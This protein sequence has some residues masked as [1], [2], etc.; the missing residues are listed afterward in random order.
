MTSLIISIL[1]I[2]VFAAGF[3][4]YYTMRRPAKEDFSSDGLKLDSQYQ[5]L[6]PLIAIVFAALTYY[7]WPTLDKQMD[8]EKVKL[9]SETLKLSGDPR[10]VN[11]SMQDFILSLRTQAFENPKR[12]DLWFELGGA[13]LRLNMEDAALASWQ[14]AIQIEENPDWMVAKAQIL[15]AKSEAE[16]RQKAIKLLQR[17]LAKAPS[18]QGALLTLGFTY[19]RGQQY[20]G[21]IAVWER[22]RDLPGL[23]QRSKQFIQQQIN[24]AKAL[25]ANRAQ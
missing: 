7:L 15:G 6:L 4:F 14:R 10:Q 2:S 18:H 12:G 23:S 11:M 21:A 25:V 16:S 19:L 13:Y 5:L 22:F 24:Q 3:I 1:L 20:E 17:A 9:E 8:W